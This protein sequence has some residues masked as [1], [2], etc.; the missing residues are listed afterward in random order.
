MPS[1][2]SVPGCLARTRSTRRRCRGCR[3]RSGTRR[4]PARRTRTATT[5]T[6]VETPANRAP[7]SA[8]VA[9]SEPVLSASTLEVV[10]D[11]VGA[12]VGPDRLV[13]LADDQP[14]ERPGLDADGF[15]P[16]IGQQVRRAREQEVAGQ[17]GDRVAVAG[18]GRHRAPADIG[19]VHHVVVVQRGQVGQLDD[20]RGGND[21]RAMRRITEMRRQDADQRAEPLAAGVDEVPGDGADEL[22][23]G[24]RPPSRS[25]ASTASRPARTEASRAGSANSTP[26][27]D[28]LT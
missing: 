8:A 13:D 10:L 25:P 9:I 1:R 5:V 22:V 11:R 26:T 17:D 28:G 3:R 6:S 18:V 19:L 21:R 27:G 15:G 2:R 20:D 4:R 7:N 23:V 16:E 14:L 24:L 12:V